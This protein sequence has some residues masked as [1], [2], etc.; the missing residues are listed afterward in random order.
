MEVERAKTR[1]CENLFGQ[2]SKRNNDNTVGLEA[3]DFI[4]KT[5]VLEVVRLKNVESFLNGKFF[6][7]G[8]GNELTAPAR[9]VGSSD[10]GNN[11]ILVFMEDFEARNCKFRRPHENDAHSEGSGLHGTN[12]LGIT[13]HRVACFHFSFFDPAQLLF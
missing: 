5:G 9:L 12:A 8:E 4:N 1:N 3:A 6:D 7:R 11:I 2:D 13:H 10:N